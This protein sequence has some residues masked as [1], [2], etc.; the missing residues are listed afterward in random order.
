M[1]RRVRRQGDVTVDCYRLLA[2]RLDETIAD[3]KAWTKLLSER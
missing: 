1:E 3:A 2:E